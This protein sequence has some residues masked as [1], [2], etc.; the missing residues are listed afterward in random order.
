MS[1]DK[2][3]LVKV[4]GSALEHLRKA[5]GL[6]IDDLANKSGGPRSLDGPTPEC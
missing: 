5:A 4:D 1:E 3:G 2:G 6:T